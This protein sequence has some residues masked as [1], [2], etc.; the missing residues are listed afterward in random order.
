MFSTLRTRFGIPGV[1]SVIALVFA[2]LGGAYAASNSAG[3]GGG[4][5]TASAKAKRGPRGPRGPQGPTGSVGPQGLPGAAGKDG[6]RGLQGEKGGQGD[7][8]IQG[9]QGNP[10]KS[11]VTGTATAGECST[12]G[13]TV[14]VAGEASTKKK[15]CNGTPG[16]PWTAGGTLPVSSTET[17]SWVLPTSGGSVFTAISFPI[18]L[19]AELGGCGDVTDPHLEEAGCHVHVQTESN[20]TDFDG[21]GAGTTGCTGSAQSPTAPSGHLCVYIG[22]GDLKH[23]N[24]GDTAIYASGTT[25][26]IGGGLVIPPFG[27]SKTGAILYT[28]QATGGPITAG[29]AQGTWA[30]TG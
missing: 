4:K 22:L 28:A 20:F 19:S 6:A 2:M 23:D 5:A 16:S 7:Q 17:G 15:I 24:P 9:I 14:E 18:P 3:G 13:A 1:I 8:G 30:V 29:W 21:A 10:G 27:A 11:V 26:D 25:V 12:G